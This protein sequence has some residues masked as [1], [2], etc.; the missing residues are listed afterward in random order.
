[1]TPMQK[2]KFKKNQ[3]N[4]KGNN[5]KY[6]CKNI[7]EIECHIEV[8]LNYLNETNLGFN[9]NQKREI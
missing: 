5:I 4:N 9:M 2:I 8:T 1:M 3:L 7:L 6:I